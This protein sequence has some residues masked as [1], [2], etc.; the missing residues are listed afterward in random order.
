V[1][2]QHPRRPQVIKGNI[3]NYKG[4]KNRTEFGFN[5][6]MQGKY[7][8]GDHA[9]SYAGKRVGGIWA[10]E[11][12]FVRYWMMF[13]FF[14]LCATLRGSATIVT[15]CFL[16]VAVILTLLAC[17]VRSRPRLPKPRL[18]SASSFRRHCRRRRWGVQSQSTG[19]E[20]LKCLS[21]KDGLGH[22][23]WIRNLCTRPH[24]RAR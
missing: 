3:Y 4:S 8:S 12:I 9:T 10:L 17:Q 2:L 1:R 19:Y 21:C 22:M 14:Y 5:D 16:A 7:R 24:R 18:T 20:S 13:S 23:A 15:P 11:W 6:D